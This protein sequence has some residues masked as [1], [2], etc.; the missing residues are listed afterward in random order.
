MVAIAMEGNPLE[1]A[2]QRVVPLKIDVTPTAG[3]SFEVVR[4]F[5]PPFDKDFDLLAKH[6]THQFGRDLLIELQKTL[7]SICLNLFR[8]IICPSLCGG[9]FAWTI[10][11]KK[12][13]CVTDIFHRFVGL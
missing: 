11:V 5:V 8:D 3:K 13:I 9:P 6:L 12:G 4:I 10:G 1:G 2:D 7:M